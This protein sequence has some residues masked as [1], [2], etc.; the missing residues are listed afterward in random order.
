MPEAPRA[1][2]MTVEM[3]EKQRQF[4][5]AMERYQYDPVYRWVGQAVSCS[6]VSLQVVLAVL[7]L[8]ATIGFFR[9]VMAFIVAYVL[10]DFVNGLVHMYMDNNDDYHSPAGP[11]VASF[12]LH[13]RTPRYVQK[14]LPAVYYHE[15]GSKLWLMPVMAGAVLGVWFGW[16]ADTVAYG[17]L[18]FGVLSSV[19]EVSHYLCHVPGTRFSRLLGKLHVLMPATYHLRH[20]TQDNINYTFLNCMTDPVVNG[21]ARLLNLGYKKTTDTHYAHYTG[22]D[23]DNRTARGT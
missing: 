15:T 21:I 9:Q 18:Y 22:L 5:A 2:G 1:G 7:V 14:P 20:H 17:L 8:P 12:H 11:L 16:V 23:T 3:T 10:A 19:A 4:N 13:H 6:I